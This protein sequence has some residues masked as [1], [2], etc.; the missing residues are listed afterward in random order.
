MADEQVIDRYFAAMRRGPAAEGDLLALFHPDAT[1]IEPFTGVSEPA[2]GITAIERRLRQGWENPL[3]DLEL[4]VLTVEVDGPT[5]TSTWECRSS[6]FS[7]P[8][9]G[10][11]DYEIRDGLIVRLEV[12][13]LGDGT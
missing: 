9:L 11:D 7:K 13:L 4:D 2:K 10:R 3:P 8:V 6:A 5:A 12:T 1:Y